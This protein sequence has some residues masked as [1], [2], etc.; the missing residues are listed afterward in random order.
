M[1]PQS[2]GGPWEAESPH[3]TLTQDQ[4]HGAV[5]FIPVYREQKEIK[6]VYNH[7]WKGKIQAN[8]RLQGL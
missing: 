6:G 5:C 1:H 7:P 8:S 4:L 2:W 3:E